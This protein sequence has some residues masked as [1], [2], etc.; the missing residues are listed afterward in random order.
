MSP[1]QMKKRLEQFFPDSTTEVFDLNGGGNH[2]EVS[3]ISSVFAGKSRIEQHQ[4]V[5]SA[6]AAELKTGEV[7]ALSIKTQLKK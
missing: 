1:D 5:M 4:A 3:V 7:H 2:Y 6:F